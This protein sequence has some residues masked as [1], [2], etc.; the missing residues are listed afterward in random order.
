MIA[1]SRFG[2]WLPLGPLFWFHIFGPR[3]RINFIIFNGL[4]LIDAFI[5][6]ASTY[7]F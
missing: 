1:S 6:T 3:N 4:K 7:K 2:A 5:N